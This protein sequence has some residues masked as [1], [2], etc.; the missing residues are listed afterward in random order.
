MITHTPTVL[1]LLYHKRSVVSVC[2]AVREAV[3][4]FDREPSC[5]F[6]WLLF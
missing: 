6:C 3:V 5:F 4:F 2:F 1:L